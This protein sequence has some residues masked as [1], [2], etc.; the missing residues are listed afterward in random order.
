MSAGYTPGPWLIHA[1]NRII[2]QADG[3]FADVKVKNGKVTGDK[4]PNSICLLRDPGDDFSEDETLANGFLIAAAPDLYASLEHI[5][6]GALS[7][8]RHAEIEG[9]AALAKARG[10]TPASPTKEDGE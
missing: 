1:T 6:N 3:A 4:L 8:P 10:E 9:R 5:L 2:V 7:L